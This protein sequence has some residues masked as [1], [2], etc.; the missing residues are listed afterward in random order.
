MKSVIDGFDVFDARA[1]RLVDVA[2]TLA[3]DAHLRSYWPCWNVSAISSTSFS[4]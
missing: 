2:S 4:T 3:A 1:H